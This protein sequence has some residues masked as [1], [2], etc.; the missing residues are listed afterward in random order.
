MK[1]NKKIAIITSFLGLAPFVVL[2]CSNQQAQTIEQPKE[3]KNIEKNITQI[4]IS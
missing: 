1:K 3:K 2:S 4:M